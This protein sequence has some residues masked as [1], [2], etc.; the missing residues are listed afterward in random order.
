MPIIDLRQAFNLLSVSALP[1]N[2][3]GFAGLCTETETPRSNIGAIL[4][5]RRD[6]VAASVSSW[7]N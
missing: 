1:A 2:L 3:A 5:K 6:C 7:R 4:V